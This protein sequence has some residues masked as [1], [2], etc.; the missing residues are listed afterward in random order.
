MKGG[1]DTFDCWESICLKVGYVGGLKG[2]LGNIFFKAGKEEG[3]C[4][5]YKARMSR[6]RLGRCVW[7]WMRLRLS[8]GAR[9]VFLEGGLIIL[10]A[11]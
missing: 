9:K 1:G 6:V 4:N 8:L 3:T 10:G 5:Y 7:L 11:L 2:S